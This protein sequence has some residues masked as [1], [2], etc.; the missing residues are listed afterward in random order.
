M[1][2]RS[3]AVRLAKLPRGGHLKNVRIFSMFVF[4]NLIFPIFLASQWW[5]KYYPVEGRVTQ[6]LS[7]YEQNVTASLFKTLPAHFTKS[8]KKLVAEAWFGFFFLVSIYTWGN[9][10]HKQVAF[11]HRA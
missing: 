11:S 6:H 8:S 5:G 4:H 2:F 10:E 9:Y 1:A 3:S 7:P